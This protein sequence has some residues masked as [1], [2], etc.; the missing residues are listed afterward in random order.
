M[1]AADRRFGFGMGIEDD[2]FA[3]LLQ[4][5]WS[6]MDVVGE[7]IVCL[8]RCSSIVCCCCECNVEKRVSN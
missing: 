2:I 7:E 6:D 5:R 8:S 1:A 4:L 3:I